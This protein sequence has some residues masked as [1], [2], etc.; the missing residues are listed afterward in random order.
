MSLKD[1]LIKNS[2]LDHT[3]LLSDSK[4][5]GKGDMITTQIPNINVALSGDV[6]GGLCPGILQI[7]GPSR[8][9]KTGFALIMAAAFLRKYPDGI[10]LF[11]DS[12]FG[13]PQSY[14]KTFGI[15]LENVIHSP[16][17]T[18][19]DLRHD[20][21][22]QYEA[23]DRSDKI[24]IILDSLGNLASK[25]ET[26]DAIDGSDKADMTRAKMTKSFFRIVGPKLVIKDIPMVIVNHT[27][28]TIEMYSKDV[29]G[30]GCLEAGTKIRMADNTLKNIEDII[31]GEEVKTLLGNKK[32]TNTWNPETLENG[33]PEC[34]EI[35][36]EDGLKVICSDEHKFSIDGDWIEAKNLNTEHKASVLY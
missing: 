35:E 34:Y 11:Y 20:F 3:S 1:K 14:F 9:F 21:S 2:T 22:V 31:T 16:V 15:P 24:M 12:E 6:D 7:A 30:G 27:Y 33:F 26:Q 28:K 17:T 32:V 36:F 18:I 8:H 25:K 4:I 23:L 29:V 5:Y 13:T 10:I 19:E